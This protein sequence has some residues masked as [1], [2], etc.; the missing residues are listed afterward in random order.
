[1]ENLIKLAQHGDKEAFAHAIAS[2][3]PVM[4]KVA[5]TRLASEEDIG[6]AIQESILSAFKNLQALKNP[7][8]FRTWLTRILI[9][10]CNDIISQN[11]KVVCMES[12]ENAGLP[13]EAAYQPDVG[14]DLDFDRV[15]QQL[16]ADYRTVVVLY[17]V[18]GFNTREIAEILSEKEGTIKSRLSRARDLIRTSYI[19]LLE[20]R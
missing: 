8:Y 17:Y 2:H 19:E 10:Q 12:L 9:N 18:N 20:V 1:M 16:K 6:D 4:Y 3:M 5:K 14:S 11:S 15:L 13:A 7:D